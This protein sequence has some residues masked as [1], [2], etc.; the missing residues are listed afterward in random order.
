MTTRQW[1]RIM[2]AEL[3]HTDPELAGD[4]DI[5]ADGITRGVHYTWSKVGPLFLCGYIRRRRV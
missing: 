4:V 2:R 1:F 3:W 5:V